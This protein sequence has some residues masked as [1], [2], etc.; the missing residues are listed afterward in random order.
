MP[1]AHRTREVR[2]APSAMQSLLSC[3]PSPEENSAI[4]NVL[5]ALAGKASYY[6]PSRPGARQ[7]PLLGYKIA[8]LVP[9]TYL[10]E[11]GRFKIRYRFDDKNIDVGYIGVL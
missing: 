2:I 3:H 4:K 9:P 1:T 8:F 7:G 5:S 11:A 6:V 10:I